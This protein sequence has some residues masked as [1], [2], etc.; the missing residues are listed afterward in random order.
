MLRAE[1][2][3]LA[4][5]YTLVATQLFAQ[6]EVF[7]NKVMSDEYEFDEQDAD[8]YEFLQDKLEY[9]MRQAGVHADLA[10]CRVKEVDNPEFVKKFRR[11]ALATPE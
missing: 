10:N 6:I 9:V 4:E 3:F 2:Y 8:R 7:H 5:D 11:E 1:H